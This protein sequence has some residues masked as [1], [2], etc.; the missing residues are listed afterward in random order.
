MTEHAVS[1]RRPEA[2]RRGLRNWLARNWH[3]GLLSL[4]TV[5]WFINMA[6]GGGIAWVFFR[7]GDAALFGEP[8]SFRPPGGLH[9]FATNPGLQIGP[10][11]FAVAEVLRYLGP[12]SGIVVA[13]ILLTADGVLLIAAIESRNLPT[14]ALRALRVK[15]SRWVWRTGRRPVPP[16]GPAPAGPAPDRGRLSAPAQPPV[17]GPRPGPRGPVGPRKSPFEPGKNQAGGRR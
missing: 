9:L 11:S 5:A 6:P 12:D 7:S 8:G 4:W 15:P 14:S 13:E 17:P 16:T 3:W 10:L 2:G 1:G